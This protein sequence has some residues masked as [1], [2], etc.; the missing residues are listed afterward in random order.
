MNKQ[1]KIIAWTIVLVIIS[2]NVY[3]FI[4]VKNET[5]DAAIKKCMDKFIQNTGV[6][7]TIARK[8]CDCAIESLKTKYLD[9]KVPPS[10]IIESEK[11]V[12]QGCYDQAIGSEKK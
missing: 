10:Q 11:D 5:Q 12:L 1:S 8:Y 9:S 6:S 2:Y 3:D 4:K 7:E